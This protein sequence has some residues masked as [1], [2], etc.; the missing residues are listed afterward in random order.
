MRVRTSKMTVFVI[1]RPTLLLMLLL[2]FLQG[3]P[4]VTAICG[5]NERA[6]AGSLDR[7]FAQTLSHFVTRIIRAVNAVEGSEESRLNA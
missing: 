6:E 5:S 4:F 7:P 2:L 3:I 1:S